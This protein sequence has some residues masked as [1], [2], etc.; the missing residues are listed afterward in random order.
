MLGVMAV[1]IGTAGWAGAELAALPTDGTGWTGDPITW[2]FRPEGVQCTV[3]NGNGIAVYEAAPRAARVTVEAVFTPQKAASDGWNVAS[4]AIVDDARNYW[5]LALVQTPAEQGCRPTVE[6]C[7]MRDGQWLAQ[8]NLRQEINEAPPVPW[9]FG[10]PHRLA[11]SMDGAG[12]TGTLLAPDGRLIL[13]R[14]FAFSAEAVTRGRPALRIGGITG[15]FSGIRAEW[16]QPVAETAEKTVTFPAYDRPDAVPDVRDAATGFFRVVQKPD[17]RW[18]AID[19]LGRGVVLLGVDHVTFHGHWCEKLGYAPHERKNREKYADHAQ[20]EAETLERLKAWGFTMLGAGSDPR[21]K[22]RGLIHTE[23]LNI[24]D[25]LASLGDEY[26]ITPNEHRPCSSFPNVFHP[27]FEAYCRYV[28]RQRCAP[29]REDPWLFGYFIDNEL[30]WWGRGGHTDT[31]LFDAVMKKGPEHSAKQ[32][33]RDFAARRAGNDVAAFNAL[34]G[35]R[36]AGFDDVL[37]LTEL[38]AATEAQRAAKLDFLRLA[39]DRYFSIATRAIRAEDPNHL[40]LGARFA[41]TGGAD[42]AVWEVSGKYCDVVTFNCYP[43]ADLDEGRVYTHFGKNGELATD[44]FAKYYDYVKRPM[45]VTEWSF[46]ALDAGLPSVHGAGQRFRTQAER[47]QAT[48]LFARTM[49]S[50]PYLLG[51]DYF[52]WVDEPALGIS[53][54]FPE[55]SNYGLINEDAVPYPLITEMFAALHR[56]AGAWRFKPAPE[57]KAVT[58]KA[59]LPAVDAARWTAFDG[60]PAFFA[61]EGDA[62]RMGNGRLVLTGRVGDGRMVQN[63]TLDGAEKGFGQYGAMVQTADPSGQYRWNEA[64]S[65]QSVKGWMEVRSTRLPYVE[66]EEKKGIAVV[67]ITGAGGTGQE[68]FEVTHRLFLPPGAPYFIAEA[69]SVKNTGNTPM[70][71][72]ALYFRLNNDFKGVPDQLPPNLWGV[73]PSGCW[74]DAAGGR[75]F[76]AVAPEATGVRVYFWLNPQGGQHPDARLELDPAVELAPGATFKPEEPA[77]VFCVAGQGDAQA[78]LARVELLMKRLAQ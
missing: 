29:A 53:T 77:Y 66:G 25:H 65:V 37:A 40:V 10:A 20:W 35:A 47:T 9:T 46:P 11:L 22:H 5:H 75:F 13:R 7:E 64:R 50:Q 56:E 39:A 57:A 70:R 45:L 67:E 27:D 3:S 76:G 59:P 48:S 44:H 51:Y 38:P 52:M 26:D 63:V 32:A 62:F 16:S 21:L 31:G 15:T 60:P 73:P 54:P 2:R 71:V 36:I 78:W 33:L 72:K 58:R 55:D 4:V 24:G 49:L 42:P 8:G 68:A 74:L 30:A 14:R 1:L 28:A 6:L 12:V 19:P 18:W 23:F 34:W 43:M 69:V 17:G 41:G 61:R